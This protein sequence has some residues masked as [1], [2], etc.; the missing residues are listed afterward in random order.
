MSLHYAR[1]LKYLNHSIHPK[2]IT[3]F[4]FRHEEGKG[5]RAKWKGMRR[6]G[7]TGREE[8]W[9]VGEGNEGKGRGGE[10]HLK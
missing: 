6:V 10:A 5:K 3:S 9:E 8:E 7:G 1:N 2:P 4:N